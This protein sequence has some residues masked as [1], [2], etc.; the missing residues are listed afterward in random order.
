MA[1]FGEGLNKKELENSFVVTKE[2]SKE[3][4]SNNDSVSAEDIL[5]FIFFFLMIFSYF[6]SFIYSL[7]N[8]RFLLGGTFF[9]KKELNSLN[10]YYLSD[11]ISSSIFPVVY[12]SIMHFCLFDKIW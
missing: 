6:L 12:L 8:R 5:I 11:K 9:V 10:L 1:S 3:N 2:E 4:S 7:L